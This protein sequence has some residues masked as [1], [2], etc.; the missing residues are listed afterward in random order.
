LSLPK[1]DAPLRPAVMAYVVS[2]LRAVGLTVDRSWLDVVGSQ[3]LSAVL[4]SGDAKLIAEA[5]TRIPQSNAYWEL[6]P[7]FECAIPA[8]AFDLGNG[9]FDTFEEF[10]FLYDRLLGAIAKPWLP[11]LFLAAASMPGLIP[12]AR[13][14]LISSFEP[15]AHF[16]E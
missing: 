2:R 6:G 5:R 13:I 11:P 1:H 14:R 7:F 16:V 3:P 15:S 8:A 12:E 4:L 9:P 10:E